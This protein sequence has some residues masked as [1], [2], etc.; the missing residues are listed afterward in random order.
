MWE[1][2]YQWDMK[3][4]LCMTCFDKKDEEYKKLKT[5]CN[6]CGKK[7]GMIRYNPKKRWIVKGQLCKECWDSKKA[8]LG[9]MHLFKKYRCDKC[10]IK[11]RQQEE[12]MQHEQITHSDNKIYDCNQC[13]QNFSSMEEMRTHLQ[14]FHTYTG[15]KDS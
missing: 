10:G 4:L 14:R 15:K 2:R 9:Q 6:I 3:G 1:P 13:G 8:K 12:L 11:F 7:L 5:F